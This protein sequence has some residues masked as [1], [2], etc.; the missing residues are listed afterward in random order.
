MSLNYFF[1]LPDLNSRRAR[2]MA[3]LSEYN[4]EPQHIKGKENKIVDDLI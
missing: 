4:L 3:F 1:D 2:G